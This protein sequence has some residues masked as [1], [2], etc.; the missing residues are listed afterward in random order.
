MHYC[1]DSARDTTA[2]V[3]SLRRTP[4]QA[5]HRINHAA[6]RRRM[7]QQKLTTPP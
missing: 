6:T 7:H 1:A 5:I 4:V 3:K 2:T